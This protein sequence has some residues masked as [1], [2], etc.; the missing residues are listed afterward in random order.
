[1]TIGTQNTRNGPGSTI[2]EQEPTMTSSVNLNKFTDSGFKSSLERKMNQDGGGGGAA[3][4][5]SA[6]NWVSQA[7]P[8]K[9]FMP[10][11]TISTHFGGIYSGDTVNYQDEEKSQF[12]R[13]PDLN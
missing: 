1:M 2:Y 12:S 6:S 9:Q 3:M 10:H 11:T 4:L 8:E 5:I 13:S 7:T